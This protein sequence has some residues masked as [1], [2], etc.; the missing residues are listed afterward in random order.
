MESEKE[1]AEESRNLTR[2]L[3]GVKGICRILTGKI[4]GQ[5]HNVGD[6]QADIQSSKRSART[7]KIQMGQI[8]I[9]HDRLDKFHISRS[10]II[11][12]VQ[13]CLIIAQ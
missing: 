6:H 4:F 3:K 13:L 11:P 7:Y 8:G 1:T 10:I 5:E 12:R 2:K 9:R